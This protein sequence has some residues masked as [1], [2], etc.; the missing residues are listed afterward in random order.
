MF[1]FEESVNIIFRYNISQNDGTAQTAVLIPSGNPSA[2]VYNN[3]FYVAE[4]VPFIKTN[5]STV[6]QMEL[7]NNIIYYSGTQQRQENWYT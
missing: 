3:T 2:K 6:G 7:T 1:C 4:N 5:G